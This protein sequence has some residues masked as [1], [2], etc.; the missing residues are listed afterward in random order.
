ML[1]NTPRMAGEIQLPGH[2][3][4]KRIGEDA[5]T[6]TAASRAPWHLW[7]VGGVLTLWGAFGAWDFTATV[8]R[9]RPYLDVF[10]PDMLTY[11]LSAPWYAYA[12]WGLGTWG[13]LIGGVLLLL[14]NKRAV[15]ALIAA[16]IGAA[17]S[18]AVCFID[19]APFA[20]PIASGAIVAVTALFLG[21]AL[22]LTR[23]GVLR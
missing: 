8:T 11:F 15:L 14:R 2:E 3:N 4:G 20:D 5:M 22:W 17:G 23:R 18:L 21:Y 16:V 12:A 13:G 9:F 7:V 1:L 6:E 19:P 10:P